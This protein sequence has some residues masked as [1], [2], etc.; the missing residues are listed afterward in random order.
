MTADLGLVAHSAEGDPHKRTPHGPGHRLAERGLPDPR[1]PG[2]KKDGAGAPAFLG[3]HP[4]LLAELADGQVLENALLDILQTGVVG[5]EHAL[6]VFEL[7]VVLRG[8]AP[9]KV[10]HGVEPGAYP[11][12]LGALLTDAL[13]PVDLSGDR[14][15]DL[16]REVGLVEL[17][18]VL[19]GDVAVFLAE[20]FPDGG[21]LLAQHIL[22]LA[23]VEPFCCVLAHLLA[24]AEL[25]EERA[26]PIEQHREPP[27][28]REGLQE[29]HLLGESQVGRV[30]GEVGQLTGIVHGQQ[31]LRQC[32]NPAV[33]EDGA[34]D[35]A[36]LGGEGCDL[37]RILDKR[38]VE[39]LDLHQEG[40]RIADLPGPDPGAGQA[41]DQ[42]AAHRTGALDLFESRN[43]ADLGVIAIDPRHQQDPPGPVLSGCD[44]AS[45]LRGLEGDGHD[46]PREYDPVAKRQNRQ[47]QRRRVRHECPSI[48]F[49]ACKLLMKAHY[50]GNVFPGVGKRKS[51]A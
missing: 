24:E 7:E 18:S 11:A 4:T 16:V 51:E 33:F 36:V 44:G 22:P 3:L 20:L 6:G 49:A 42:S 48:R 26:H 1:R 13:Q 15:L 29:L 12:V 9:G 14:L 8:L 35:G 40:A 45:S 2:E 21:H 43:G 25:A 34:D 19:T 41:P 46:H 50:L 31:P 5:V 30:C 37:L 28:D 27:L 17:R 47:R 32:G 10:E 23:L 39:D 38:L